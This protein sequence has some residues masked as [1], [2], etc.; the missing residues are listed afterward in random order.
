MS[1]QVVVLYSVTESPFTE[2]LKG[3]TKFEMKKKKKC[4]ITF[5]ISDKNFK[6][7]IYLTSEN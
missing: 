1:N 5:V 7:I 3:V 6:I 2:E 4:M